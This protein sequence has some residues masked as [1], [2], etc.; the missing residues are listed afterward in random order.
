MTRSAKVFVFL[1]I[2]AFGGAGAATTAH[3]QSATSCPGGSDPNARACLQINL[4]GVQQSLIE[5]TEQDALD[6][7]GMMW[8]IGGLVATNPTFLDEWIAVTQPGGAVSDIVGIPTD[9]T[10]AFISSPAD[11]SLF[12]IFTT[13][14]AT[15][16][17]IDVS[18]LL[19][20]GA[21][22]EGFTALFQTKVSGVPEPS[23]W[24]MMLLGFAGLGYAG[25]RQ[26]AA[27]RRKSVSLVD[28]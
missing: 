21:R 28:I 13:V 24:A 5:I 10:I 25:F 23:T 4:S 9:G 12:T 14:P 11:F 7:P 18:E 15:S 2:L 26:R 19:S 6:N 27:M 1:A 20:L 17:P 16:S 22:A 8:M 3:A